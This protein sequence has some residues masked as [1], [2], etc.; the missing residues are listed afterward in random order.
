MQEMWCGLI[1]SGRGRSEGALLLCAEVGALGGALTA[2]ST[3]EH[4]AALLS[5]K[6]V[7]GH[8]E[9]AAGKRLQSCKISATSHDSFEPCRLL[10]QRRPASHECLK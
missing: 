7:Y 3:R 2:Q 10:L 6:S 5:V 9:G 8:T 1:L 4:T